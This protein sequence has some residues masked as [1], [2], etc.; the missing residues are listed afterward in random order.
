MGMLLWQRLSGNAELDTVIDRLIK[1]EDVNPTKLARSRWLFNVALIKRIYRTGRCAQCLKFR[2]RW[3]HVL[4]SL[5]CTRWAHYSVL[6]L[7]RELLVELTH[8]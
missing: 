6:Y 2:G 7:C 8:M 3:R 1:L 4:S 5:S